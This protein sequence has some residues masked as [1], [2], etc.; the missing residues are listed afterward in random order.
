MEMKDEGTPRKLATATQR[1][2]VASFLDV[3]SPKKRNA[4]AGRCNITRLSSKYPITTFYRDLFALFQ[5]HF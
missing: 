4:A 3:S 1:V 5:F 2:A